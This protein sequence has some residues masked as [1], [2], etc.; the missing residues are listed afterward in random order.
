MG[1]DMYLRA[2][3]YIYGW[4]EESE[5][6]RLSK[7][8]AKVLGLSETREVRCVKVDAGYWRKAN[9]IHKWFVE[10]VQEGIDDCGN[11]EVSRRDLL[12]LKERC[13]Q[14]LEDKSLAASLLPTT[15]GF[16]FGATEYEDWYYEDLEE[17][18]KIIDDALSFPDSWSFEYHSSW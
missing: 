12:N 4:Q 9:Q 10:N 8:I 3:R 13:E 5:D 6:S 16:F 11:Y 2:E 1:L 15:S 14:V 17:T 18:I 7:E